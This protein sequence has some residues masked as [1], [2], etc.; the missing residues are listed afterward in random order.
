MDCY[1]NERGIDSDLCS[2][3]ENNP[4]N[5]FNIDDIEQVL[6]VYEGE[7]DGDNWHWVLELTDGRFVYLWGGC[8]YTGW[9]CQSQADHRIAPNA[10]A[11]AHYATLIE[12]EEHNYGYPEG[13]DMSVYLLNQIAEGK[14]ETWREKMDDEFGLSK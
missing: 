12:M 11:A 10:T 1:N 14:R 7:N 4:Q 9:D 5:G 13:I 2:C 3:L 8:D 6:A